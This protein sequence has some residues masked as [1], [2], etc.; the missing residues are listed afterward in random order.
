MG[1]SYLSGSE[2]FCDDL[3]GKKHQKLV[4]C[5]SVFAVMNSFGDLCCGRVLLLLLA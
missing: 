5:R 1:Q 2:K 3:T 4:L